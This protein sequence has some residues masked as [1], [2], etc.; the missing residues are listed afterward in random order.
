MALT[1]NLTPNRHPNRNRHPHPNRH[2]NPSQAAAEALCF[3]VVLPGWRDSAGW[4]A[5]ARSPLRRAT[6]QIAAADHGFVDGAP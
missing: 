1:V 6:L 3:V 4:Q 5:L 2:P